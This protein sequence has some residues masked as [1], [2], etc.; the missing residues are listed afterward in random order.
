ME[1][2]QKR[3]R[4]TVVVAHGVTSDDDDDADDARY[5][6]T[7][8]L[9]VDDGTA[10][11][12][13]SDA[14]QLPLTT[15]V[16]DHLNAFYDETR[17]SQEA[18]W[19]CTHNPATFKSNVEELAFAWNSAEEFFEALQF[20]LGLRITSAG[21]EAATDAFLAACVQ[22]VAVHDLVCAPMRTCHKETTEELLGS[23]VRGFLTRE[24]GILNEE[25]DVKQ[26]EWLNQ[27]AAKVAAVLMDDGAT[28]D[29]EEDT[30]NDDEDKG[31]EEEDDDDDDDDDDEGEE[32][33]DDD[34]DDDDDDDGGEEEDEE[35]DPEDV[36]RDAL[37]LAEMGGVAS[38]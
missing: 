8:V 3:Q 22:T 10:N 23:G 15:L 5:E 38:P 16:K 13:G 18:L 36:A 21:R 9:E 24:I 32:E 29:A 12:A 7:N 35:D 31:E 26:E 37:E 19:H 33:E 11:D 25:L 28:R 4:R 34:D 17:S 1:R 6:A 20:E 27:T 14:W 2:P 30:E